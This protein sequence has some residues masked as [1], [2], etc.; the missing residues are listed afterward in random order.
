[1][2]GFHTLIVQKK[3]SLDFD[4]TMEFQ[5]IVNCQANQIFG[6]EALVRG[7]NNESAFSIISKVNTDNRYLF[8]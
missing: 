8:A 7:L 6:Y 2:F 5:P 3:S 1:M 4:L